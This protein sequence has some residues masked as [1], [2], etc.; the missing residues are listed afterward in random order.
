MKKKGKRTPNNKTKAKAVKK[1]KK[2]QNPVYTKEEETEKEEPK[3][4]TTLPW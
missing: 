1:I 3:T 2:I 4:I